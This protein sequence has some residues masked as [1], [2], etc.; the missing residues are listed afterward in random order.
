MSFSFSGKRWSASEKVLQ[1]QPRRQ[2]GTLVP[3]KGD[4]TNP[5]TDLL[6]TLGNVL[7]NA[8]IRPASRACK[9]RPTTWTRC[10][11]APVS[12]GS[13]HAD[14]VK[15]DVGRRAAAPVRHA[16]QAA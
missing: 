5:R 2:F 15:E 12:V 13:D 11:S 4:L 6:A 9:A 8:F 3:F 7:R 16:A 14:A 1:N 10:G